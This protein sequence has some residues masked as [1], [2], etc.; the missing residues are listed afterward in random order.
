MKDQQ[1][2][3][4]DQHVE[5]NHDGTNEVDVQE[6]GWLFV[7]EF[8]TIQYHKPTSLH[9]FYKEKSIFTITD[10]ANNKSSDLN[11]GN[12]NKSFIGTFEIKKKITE[13]DLKECKVVVS[14]VDC[15]PSSDNGIIVQVVGKISNHS[16]PYKK[17]VR[18][19]FLAHQPNGYYVLNDIYK[20]LVS[21]EDSKFV[22][23]LV[24][25]SKSKKDKESKVKSKT[26]IESSDASNNSALPSPVPSTDITKTEKVKNEGNSTHLEKEKPESEPTPKRTW[27]KL[28]STSLPIDEAISS[29]VSSAKIPS[30]S[31]V[32]KDVKPLAQ[33]PQVTSS[34][35]SRSIYI[36]S[37]Q[38]PITKEQLIESFGKFGEVKHVDL[39]LTRNIAFVEYASVESVKNAVGKQVIIA[40]MV[41]VGEERKKKTF[42]QNF[43]NSVNGSNKFKKFSNNNS[44]NKNKSN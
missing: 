20:M 4:V 21:K 17:F 29:T 2:I 23:G 22:E 30:T 32:K 31:A 38:D 12:T 10:E 8:F 34:K 13:L 26:T 11:S 5:E 15:Q 43:E 42:N 33:T 25:K 24:K 27:A 40:G 18:T 14:D 41:L 35:D 19:F 39:L 37:V 1:Q 9:N 44:N 3:K 28:A 6:I 7:Q 16:Q 36:R